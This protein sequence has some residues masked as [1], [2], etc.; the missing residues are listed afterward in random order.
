MVHE[1]FLIVEIFDK[2]G[3]MISS[4][5]K[6]YQLKKLYDQQKKEAEEAEREK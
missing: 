4:T 1:D 6:T 5:A 2:E 3:Q